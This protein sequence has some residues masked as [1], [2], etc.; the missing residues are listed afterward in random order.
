MVDNIH[1]TKI[2]SGFFFFM[3]SLC[4]CSPLNQSFELSD[5]LENMYTAAAQYNHPP[6]FPVTVICNGIDEASFG[7]NILDKIYS[8]VVARNGNGTCKINSPTNKSETLEGWEW[9]VCRVRLF[10]TF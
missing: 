6:E 8:G 7:N 1:P 5:Y 2:S 9:Q 10:W 3:L 4:S